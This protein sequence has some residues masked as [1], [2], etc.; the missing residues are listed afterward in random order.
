MGL[1]F[2]NIRRDGRLTDV[3]RLAFAFLLGTAIL[4]SADLAGTWR[5][6]AALSLP[7]TLR[8]QQTG[9]SLSGT[10]EIQGNLFPVENGQVNGARFTFTIS[11][12]AGGRLRQI[13]V[14]G[15]YGNGEIRLQDGAAGVV[16]KRVGPEADANR[17][18]RLASLIRLWGTIRF[19]HP[20]V[21]SRPIDWDSAFTSAVQ[22]TANAA[23]RD[24]FVQAISAMLALLGDS[25]T[26]VLADDAPVPLPVACRCREI[27]R[28]GF[29]GTGPSTAYYADWENVP[30]R[31]SYVMKLW[32][33]VRVALRTAEPLAANTDIRDADDPYAGD[34]PPREYRLL[35]LARYWNA[36]HYFYGYPDSLGAWDAVLEEFIPPFE[37]AQTGRD[38]RSGHIPEAC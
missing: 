31:A 10:E 13:P 19:F 6:D 26:R 17:I 33:G 24:D 30:E 22:P 5:G 34:L 35:G 12:P 27:V 16:L 8:L 23:S 29:V 32:N 37:A 14:A 4:F 7:V 20:Y 1:K 11:V 38:Y 18:E 9:N 25:E 36:I 28:S 2:R 15:T 21:A 3:I